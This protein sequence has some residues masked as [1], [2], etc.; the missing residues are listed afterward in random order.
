MDQTQSYASNLYLNVKGGEN[1]ND[2]GRWNKDEEVLREMDVIVFCRC[3]ACNP[4]EI[5]V[6]PH[7]ILSLLPLGP[8]D[9]NGGSILRSDPLTTVYA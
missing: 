7:S 2:R 9:G 5:R 8:P 1:K 4:L 6:A 3:L